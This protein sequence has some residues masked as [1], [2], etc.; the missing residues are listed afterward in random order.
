VAGRLCAIMTGC[1]FRHLMGDGAV[2]NVREVDLL[3]IAYKRS[4]G[5]FPQQKDSGR[6][7]TGQGGVLDRIM[8]LSSAIP[9]CLDLLAMIYSPRS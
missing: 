7:L 6:L 8:S 9:V 5:I 3:G 2:G 4:E 1:R